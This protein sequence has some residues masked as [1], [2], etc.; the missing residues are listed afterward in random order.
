MLY[1]HFKMDAEQTCDAVCL[2]KFRFYYFPQLESTVDCENLLW[3]FTVSTPTF[4]MTFKWM[5]MQQ[6]PWRQWP[7]SSRGII[8]DN[9]ICLIRGSPVRI[10]FFSPLHPSLFS[11]FPMFFMLSHSCKR[12]KM[13]CQAVIQLHLV[14]CL[15]FFCRVWIMHD[16]HN[17]AFSFGFYW[18]R[19]ILWSSMQS[20]H[21]LLSFVW[22]LD[23]GMLANI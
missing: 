14:F 12:C 6:I 1:L 15:F 21:T 8:T 10:A 20:N 16:V 13:L 3:E 19:L 7:P 4:F 5:Q 17:Y 2:N 18:K 23:E 22:P 11:T 9:V